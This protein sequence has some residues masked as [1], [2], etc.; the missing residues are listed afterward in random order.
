[1][2][3]ANEEEAV[4]TS[5]FSLTGVATEFEL[6]LDD[7][8]AVIGLA[9]QVL[10]AMEGDVPSSIAFSLWHFKHKSIE[11]SPSERANRTFTWDSLVHALPYLPSTAIDLLLTNP[12]S[13]ERNASL[14]LASAVR[15][16]HDILT[17]KCL[18][19]ITPDAQLLFDLLRICSC[20]E[21][22]Y[23]SVFQAMP[24]QGR[25]ILGA[26]QKNQVMKDLFC[27]AVRYG[28][29]QLVDYLLGFDIGLTKSES[30]EMVFVATDT[31]QIHVVQQLAKIYTAT[32]SAGTST[33]NSPLHCASA[34]NFLGIARILIACGAS[35]SEKGEDGDTP[36]H[37]A[38]RLGHLEMVKLLI[39]ANGK[40]LKRRMSASLSGN[41]EESGVTEEPKSQLVIEGPLNCDDA[42]VIE[43]SDGSIP[44]E[45]AIRSGNK[46]VAALLIKSAPQSVLFSR[47]LL[48]I[49]SLCGNLHLLKC[50]L[51][52]Q[53]LDKDR[54]DKRGMTALTLAC[55]MGHVDVVQE[56]IEQGAEAWPSHVDE[57]Q[58]PPGKPVLNKTLL[59]VALRGNKVL[60]T[61]LLDAGADINTTSWG[62]R[63]PLHICAYRNHEEAVRL[64]LIRGADRSVLDSVKDSPLADATSQCHLGI[65]RL[66]L[67]AGERYPLN[68]F[69]CPLIELTEKGKK[70]ALEV[71]LKHQEEFRGSEV[72]AK[73]FYI[74]L[75]NDNSAIVSLL[76]DHDADPNA[77]TVKRYHGNAIHECALYGNIKMA[78]V[79][80]DY[81]GGVKGNKV[82]SLTSQYHTPLIAAVARSYRRPRRWLYQAEK[83]DNER[84]SKQQKMVEF[85]RERGGDTK[86]I[87]G[88]FGTMLNAAAAQAQPSLVT[89]ILD[90]VG[91]NVG[92][93]DHEGRSAA[94]AACSGL[95]D[96][97]SVEIL[98]L[99]SKRAGYSDLLW[100]P[101]KHGRLPLHFACGGQRQEVL[102]YLLSDKSKEDKF[103]QCDNDGWTPLHWAC[104]GWSSLCARYLLKKHASADIDKATK[105]GWKPWDVA[106]FH[107]NTDFSFLMNEQSPMRDA[108][109]KVK[110]GG[111]PWAATCDSCYCPDFDLCFKCF[112]MSAKCH[113]EG[114]E[115]RLREGDHKLEEDRAVEKDKAA[116]VT[117]GTSEN[118]VDQC[119]GSD[120]MSEGSDIFDYVWD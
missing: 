109:Y 80:L 82:N 7:A 114:H 67:E 54:K 105:E 64:L 118:L 36:V 52:V 100:T 47:E 101:D 98:D 117:S 2:R 35:I 116:E 73:C 87:G 16:G 107:R 10:P 76:L 50:L 89:Y 33:Q 5:L 14:L 31:G 112:S 59:A 11:T 74:A 57:D 38:A 53:G 46:A 69:H 27:R 94:H 20:L 79:L 66:L 71:I 93:V 86:I 96:L 113:E 34:H 68:G 25:L 44:I 21:N 77:E 60:I 83:A 51:E 70:D 115:F 119:L 32:L 92:D 81:P 4:I 72:L 91:F 3:M 90:K 23:V 103:R 61:A 29:L 63:T 24:D 99:L 49:T 95:N 45:V 56:L 102:R 39:D 26:E 85:L 19:Y 1:M 120:H 43:N 48:H 37:I 97:D 40:E 42:L 62:E 22:G 110:I 17:E 55:T 8:V 111:R 30:L 28:H 12:E 18:E 41:T 108:D 104:R 78:R 65:M 88:R 6:Q 15:H 75:R 58:L 106:V 13:I 84:L 9:T